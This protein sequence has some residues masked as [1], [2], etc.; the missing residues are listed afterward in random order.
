MSIRDRCLQLLAALGH[1]GLD[2]LRTW[3]LIRIAQQIATQ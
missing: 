3:Q 2:G 1:V